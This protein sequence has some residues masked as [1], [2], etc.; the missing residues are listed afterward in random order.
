M[1]HWKNILNIL[2]KAPQMLINSK[3]NKEI[4]EKHGVK[5]EED[6][7]SKT[8]KKFCCGEGK[9]TSVVK[10]VSGDNM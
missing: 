10:G 1:Q 7:W 6:I 4:K 9:S 3:V 2:N 5:N 8:P